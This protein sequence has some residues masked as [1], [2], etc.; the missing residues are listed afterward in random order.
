MTEDA[1][2]FRRSAVLV[3]GPRHLKTGMARIVFVD[4]EA[5]SLHKASYPIEVAWVF[6]SGEAEDHLIRPAPA[7]TD[8]AASAEHIHG[9]PRGRLLAEGTPHDA[10]AARM[11]DQ[12]SGHALYATAPSW[13]GQW[14]SK[15]LRTAGLPRHALRLA[16]TEEAHRRVALDKFEAAGVPQAERKPLLAAVLAEAARRFEAAKNTAHRAL[17][18]ARQELER[19]RAVA[20][21][22]EAA[23]RGER[24]G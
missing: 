2:R 19:W 22:A 1:D 20:R 5:S 18:D 6:D 17:P 23:A 4:F 15:L 13:D 8:W 16:D 3:N 21:L 24:V 10:V 9:I 11:V 14:L 12:L 7:W